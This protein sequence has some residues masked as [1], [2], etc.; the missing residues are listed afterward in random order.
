ME[1][2]R[3]PRR[4]EKPCR[5]NWVHKPDPAAEGEFWLLYLKL[6]LE[7][8]VEAKGRDHEGQNDR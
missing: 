5:V 6:A 7:V 1:N 4:A 8:M 3:K 2:K